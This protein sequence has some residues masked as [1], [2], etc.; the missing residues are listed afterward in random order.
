MQSNMHHYTI[1]SI[2]SGIAFFMLA[3]KH[4]SLPPPPTT[5]EQFFLSEDSQGHN[6]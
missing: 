2:H 4:S 5:T 3:V 6:I 1:I